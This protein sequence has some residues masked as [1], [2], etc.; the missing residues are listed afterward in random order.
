MRHSWAWLALTITAGPAWAQAPAPDRPPMVPSREASVLYRMTRPGAPPVEA[1]ITTRAGGSPM[2]IDMPD[3]AYVLVDQPTHRVAMVVPNEQM[4]VGLPFEEGPQAQFQ[5]N[6]RMRFTRRGFDTVAGLRCTTWDVLLDRARSA[7]CITDDGIMLR[8]TGQDEAG[9][10]TLV[11]AVS[12]SF[13]PAQ[14]SDFTP[15]PD[16]ERMEAPSGPA[17][18]DAPPPSSQ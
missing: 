14:D 8:S 15:P 1:R 4:V 18:P 17:M 9:R 13:T 16:F 10:R 5:L 6:E 12:V 7:I 3:G 11:E 2:R